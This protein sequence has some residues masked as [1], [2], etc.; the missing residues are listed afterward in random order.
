MLFKK[1]Y[2]LY[3]KHET[4]LDDERSKRSIL[5]EEFQKRMTLVTDDLNT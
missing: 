2:D 3:L 4:M 5:A 1:N